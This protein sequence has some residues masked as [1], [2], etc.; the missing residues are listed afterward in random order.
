MVT[1]ADGSSGGGSFLHAMIAVDAQSGAVL[2]AID[3]QFLARSSGGKARRLDRPHALRQPIRWLKATERAGERAG[4]ITGAARVTMVA[5][6]EADIFDRFAHR[7][8]HVDGPMSLC[9][10]RCTGAGNP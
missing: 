5:D 7:P 4:E 6:R 3:A 8:A 2:G 1:R 10:C 9:P